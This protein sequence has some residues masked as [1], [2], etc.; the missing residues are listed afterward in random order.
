MMKTTRIA[1]VDD[2]PSVRKA[3]SRLLRV[4]R[5]TVDTYASADEFLVTLTTRIPDCLVL[6]IRL[7]GMTG[8]ALRE[9]LAKMGLQIPIVFISAHD[10]DIE[11]QSSVSGE[12]I[13][14]LQK[15]FDDHALLD[16]I[17]RARRDPESSTP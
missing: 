13:P 5:M 2:D 14:I 4:A 6:D 11:A 3:L 10:E 12:H 7:S 1:V 8:P 15:P 16:A 9:H 17:R